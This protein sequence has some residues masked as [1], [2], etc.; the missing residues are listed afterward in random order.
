MNRFSDSKERFNEPSS[1]PSYDQSQNQRGQTGLAD[2][3]FVVRDR[4]AY[5]EEFRDDSSTVS[6]TRP[7]RM[8]SRSGSSKRTVRE[9]NQDRKLLERLDLENRQLEKVPDLRQEE[10][11]KLINLQQ[12]RINDLTNLKYLRNLVFLDLYDNEISDLFHLQPLINLRVLM[13]GKNKIDRIHGLENLTKLDVLDMH[14]NNISELSGLTH[15][16][17]LRVLNLAGNKISQVHGL[18]K[19]E[20]LAE[21]NVSRNQVVNVQDLEKLPYLASVYLSYNKIAKWEDI[22][23]LGDSVSLKEL[24]LD[25]NPLTFEN[26]YRYTVLASG[27]KLKMLDAKRVSDEERRMASSLLKKEL[28]KKRSEELAKKRS[29]RRQLAIDNVLRLWKS[30][31]RKNAA[32]VVSPDLSPFS[33]Q[34]TV[35]DIGDSHLIEY[36]PDSK[37][38][39]LFGTESIQHVEKVLATANLGGQIHAIHL[40]YAAGAQFL[41]K[42]PRLRSRLPSL[43]TLF[44]G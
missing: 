25:G 26:S 23:C 31:N 27:I 38:V 37:T 17:S 15:Q 30:E 20:S 7:S 14:S 29:Q 12:N 43:T 6:S 2:A 13:L 8:S 36:W 41:D 4:K 1:R 22:W 42:L 10:S 3:A 11:L 18:Q 19:L 21:L 39:R 40:R 32:E 5:Q 28:E 9:M 44:F 33:G 24:A 35:L 16:S 34:V